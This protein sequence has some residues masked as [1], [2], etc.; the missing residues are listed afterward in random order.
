MGARSARRTQIALVGVVGLFLVLSGC[1]SRVPPASAAGTAKGP[2][3]GIYW[4]GKEDASQKAIP[5]QP[6][7]YYDP[8]RP[9][10]LFIHGWEPDQ[11]YTHRTLVWTYQDATTGVTTTFDLAAPWIDAGWN[12]GVFDW[13]PFAD[14]SKVLEAEAKIWTAKGPRGMRWRDRDGNYQS[15]GAPQVSASELLYRNYMD[16]LADYRGP[17][18]RIA[19]HSMGNQMATALV[20]HLLE[21]LGREEVSPHLLPSRLTLL[22]PYWSP[23]ARD[24]LNQDSTGDVVRRGIEG[25]ILPEGILVEWYRS[26]LLTGGT[27]ISDGNEAL[28]AEVVF[29]EMQPR[30]CPITQQECK[31]EASWQQYLLSFGSAPPPECERASQDAPCAATGRVGALASTPNERLAD[32]LPESATWVQTVG[33]DGVDG[34]LT[35][36]TSD[37]W[38]E[39]VSTAA[40][41]P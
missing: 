1:T 29:S 41:E 2:E 4:Y 8:T 25:S 34:R 28:Q 19:G 40:T 18:I 27:L 5:G 15:E 6:N 26:S 31:H 12:I 3:V 9:T 7:P 16:V 10:M 32:M 39:R 38:Y 23:P 20:L 21:T 37:D 33:P 11:A 14:E 35:P 17:E 22:D 36:I 13:G 24:F 30:F